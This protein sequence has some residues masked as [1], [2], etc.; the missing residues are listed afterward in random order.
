MFVWMAKFGA[1]YGVRT[2]IHVGVDV[3]VNRMRDTT[4]AQR[5]VL[6]GL[7]AARCSPASSARWARTSSISMCQTEQHSPD[8]EAPMWIVYLGD[9]ARLLADVLP[10][11]AGRRRRSARTG[12]LPHHMTCTLRASSARARRSPAMS[13]SRAGTLP[14]SSGAG[15][16]SFLIAAPLLIA[17]ICLSPKFGIIVLPRRPAHRNH[18]RAAGRADA[19]GHADLDRAR[20]DGADLPVHADRRAASSR[21]R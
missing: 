12:E 10:L 18:L 13:K 2:G 8:L 1:A 14:E 11:P 15:L 3:L 19:D 6:F 16:G 9:S 20:P 21:W 7:L 4:P 17:A 5:V